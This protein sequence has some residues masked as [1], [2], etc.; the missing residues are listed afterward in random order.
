MIELVAALLFLS[1]LMFIAYPFF[2][3]A[4]AS[5]TTIRTQS[6]LD[7]LL[8]EKEEAYLSL[9]DIELDFR[10]GKLS[11][12]D[13]EVL[14]KESENRAIEVLKQIEATQASLGS[15]RKTIKAK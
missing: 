6:R 7:E 8:N 3:A 13:Y 14:K 1:L 9:K 4:E 5:P 2:Q 15:S 12:R 10:M 11:G